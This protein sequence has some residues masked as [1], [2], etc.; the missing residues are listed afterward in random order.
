M[1]FSELK[2]VGEG[3]CVC[4]FSCYEMVTVAVYGHMDMKYLLLVAVV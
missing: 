2:C 1:I 4:V 3:V